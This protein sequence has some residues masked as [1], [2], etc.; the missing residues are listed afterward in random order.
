MVVLN[1]FWLIIFT[2][3]R[4]C[5]YESIGLIAENKLGNMVNKHIVLFDLGVILCFWCGSLLSSPLESVDLIVCISFTMFKLL[6]ND[7]VSI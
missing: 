1:T 4:Y 6:V 2:G 7:L 3:K 5:I